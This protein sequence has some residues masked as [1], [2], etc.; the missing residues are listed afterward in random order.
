[1]AEQ[2]IYKNI[3][4]GDES[5]YGV[6]VGATATRLQVMEANLDKN[7]GKEKIEDTQSTARGRDRMVRLK[8]EISG[9][10]SGYLSP[11]NL[12]HAVE[13]VNGKAGISNAGGSSAVNFQYY[14]NA[15]ENWL[16]KTIERDNNQTQERFSGVA[17]QSIEISSSD[18]LIEFSLG[19][20]AKGVTTGVALPD[21]VGETIDPFSFAD[22]T[23]TLYPGASVNGSG[24]NIKPEEWA[25]SYENGLEPSYFNS[26]TIDR[27]DPK[28][29]NVSGSFKIFHEGTTFV[30]ATYGCSEW[31]L[32]IDLNLPNCGGLIAGATPYFARIDIPRIELTANAKPYAQNEFA[33][34]E[35]E[36]EGLYNY[37]VSALWLVSQVVD[38]DYV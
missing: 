3:G 23:M 36:F 7:P 33:V 25:V 6:A 37:G 16:S 30:H 9:D 5:T 21:A 10:I 26:R 17:A 31:Y 1:M 32:R 4:I 2:V 22:V 18:N 34:E 11:R 38:L 13:M 12:H 20:I 27:V 19:V 14:Q 15:G 28:I 24:I 35:I 8:T 29:P